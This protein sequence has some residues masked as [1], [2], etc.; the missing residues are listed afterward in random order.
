MRGSRILSLL[1]CLTVIAGVVVAA[2]VPAARA[3]TSPWRWQNPLPNGETLK[4]VCLAPGAGSSAVWTVGD[5]GTVLYSADNGATWSAKASGTT[6]SL[7]GVDMINDN[8]GWAVGAYG[9]VVKIS[10]GA[11]SVQAEPTGQHIADVDVIDATHAWA[12]GSNGAIIRTV[13]GTDWTTVSSPTI[14][15]LTAVQ[16]LNA[17]EGWVAGYNNALYYTADAGST[18]RFKGTADGDFQI[19]DFWV[20]GDTV[21]A[22][23]RDSTFANRVY[24]ATDGKIHTNLPG[25]APFYAGVPIGGLSTAVTSLCYL[26]STHLWLTSAAGQVMCF[27]GTTWTEQTTPYGYQWLYGVDFRS[28]ST[29]VVVGSGGAIGRTSTGGSS[30]AARTSYTI[31]PVYG[32]DFVSL[33]TGYTVSGQDVLKTTDGGQSWAAMGMGVGHE[34]LNVDFLDATHGAAVGQSGTVMLNTGGAAWTP[35]PYSNPGI[36]LRGASYQSPTRLWA[37]GINGTICW[38]DGGAWHTVA[39]SK[40]GTNLLFDIDFFDANHGI[41]VGVNGIVVYTTDGGTTWTA[42]DSGEGPGDRIVGVDMVSSTVGFIVGDDDNGTNSGMLMKKTT[43]GGATWTPMT[44]PTSESY[45]PLEDV[46]FADVNNGWIVGG[47]GSWYHTTNGGD[48][49]TNEVGNGAWPVSVFAFS[50]TAAWA[51]TNYGGILTTTPAPS[52]V[53]LVP[54][55][56]FYNFTNSTHFFTPSLDEAN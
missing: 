49:W 22:V 56:R 13:N 19:A 23:G 1:V 20:D 8:T 25:D 47:A 55:Y 15:Y 6:A 45:K 51:G 30:W 3:G 24:T 42:G 11:C 54:V 18:W 41:A 39:D 37:C 26:D 7:A 53:V 43:D 32:L 27:N 2:P 38:W 40:A 50:P 17:N 36:E 5:Y 14:Q 4:A 46:S 44:P 10:G 21:W 34:L 48:T 28:A 33:T 35:A 9:T 12:V 52:T 29:G 31:N 16:F